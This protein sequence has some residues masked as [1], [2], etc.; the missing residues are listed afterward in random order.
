LGGKSKTQ[1]HE[2]IK[3]KMYRA[4]MCDNEVRSGGIEVLKRGQGL[5]KKNGGR[6][7]KWKKKGGQKS[8]HNRENSRVYQSRDMSFLRHSPRS[9][10]RM[11]ADSSESDCQHGEWGEKEKGKSL[12]RPLVWKSLL[13]AKKLYPLRK[14]AKEFPAGRG[15]GEMRKEVNGMRLKFSYVKPRKVTVATSGKFKTPNDLKKTTRGR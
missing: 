10:R 7:A 2:N 9:N 6:K 12:N 8:C 13:P 5:K 11:D 3:E 15:G 1:K 14:Q 4:R